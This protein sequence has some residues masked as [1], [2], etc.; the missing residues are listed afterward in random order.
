M[1]R[2]A[3]GGDAAARPGH[4]P[5]LAG[6]IILYLITF[7]TGCRRI[8][9]SERQ[10]VWGVLFC[11]DSECTGTKVIR[12]STDPDFVGRCQSQARYTSD[13]N[14]GSAMA[15]LSDPVRCRDDRE[16]QCRCPWP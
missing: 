2:R 7:L 9:H 1:R 3:I 5:E 8:V 13:Y 11:S 12:S 4:E 14:P 10:A 16:P 15:T 6:L